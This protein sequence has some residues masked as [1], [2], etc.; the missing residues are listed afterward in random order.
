MG[1]KDDKKDETPPLKY[2][3]QCPA[4]ISADRVYCDSCRE[5]LDKLRKATE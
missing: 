2:C 3:A 4:V 5:A 1:K